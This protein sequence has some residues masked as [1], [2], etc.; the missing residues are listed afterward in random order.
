M[1]IHLIWGDDYASTESEIESLIKKIIDPAWISI[2]CTRLNGSDPDQATQALEE[3]RTPPFGTGGRVV[4]V[5]SSPFCN[6]CSTEL[7]KCFEEILEAIPNNTH[8]ILN[9][10]NKPDGRLKTTKAL[11]S[12]IKKQKAYEKSYLL[13]AIWDDAGQKLLVERTAE[14]LGLELSNDGKSRLVEAIGNDSTR[15]KSELEKLAL[16]ASASKKNI[17]TSQKKIFISTDTIHALVE[18]LA[19]NSL[20]IGESLLKGEIGKAIG[21]IN[22]LLDKGEPPLRILA[23]LTSQVRGCLWVTLLES[24]GENDV[25]IIAKAAGIANPKRIYVIRKQLKGMKP[26]RFI[27]LLESLLEIEAA[28]KMGT[29]PSD[30]FKDGLLRDKSF[31]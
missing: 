9:N 4:L 13:P 12:L 11:K 15:L 18:G 28:I 1:P 23:T 22:S 17:D 5:K 3:V 2:N 24:Q 14:M 25:G 16:L 7:A 6:G 30:A 31:E 8:L 21:Q 29:I 10:Q 26:K 19:T 27:Q 20:Q